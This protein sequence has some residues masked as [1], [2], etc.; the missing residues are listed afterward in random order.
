MIYQRY[1]GGRAKEIRSISANNE[2]HHI[3]FDGSI[4]PMQMQRW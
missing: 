3:A 1:I 2:V 4:E